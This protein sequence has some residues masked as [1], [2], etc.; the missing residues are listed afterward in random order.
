MKDCSAKDAIKDGIPIIIGFIPIAIAFGILSH[1]AGISALE[2]VGFS[3]FV[4]A[5]AS[6]F[7]AINLLIAGVGINEII[8]TTFLINFRHVLFSASLSTKINSKMH[9]MIPLFAFGLTDEIFSIA[10]LKRKQLSNEYILLLELTAYLSLAIGTLVG[11]FLGEL[12]PEVI[13]KSVGIALY[14]LFISIIIPEMKS[15]QKVIKI[16]LISGIINILSLKFLNF[17]QGWCMIISIFIASFLGLFFKNKG[18]R[19]E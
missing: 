16:F 5:G 11:V 17:S 12:L 15:T 18:I 10:S 7:I 2:S 13:Q 1:K 8:V 6:Q 9:K 14:A 3:L 4:F 19:Y